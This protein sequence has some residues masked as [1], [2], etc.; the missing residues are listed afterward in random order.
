M[1]KLFIIILLIGCCGVGSGCQ[2]TLFR[3]KHEP[4]VKVK[5]DTPMGLLEHAGLLQKMGDYLPAVAKYRE[6]MVC[7]QDPLEIDLAKIG[8]AECLLKEKKYPAALVALE[9]LPLDIST[10]T[11]TKKLV[12]A[13]EI[14]LRQR[15]YAEAK[16][17][18]EIAM[19][20][21]DLETLLNRSK[22]EEMPGLENW[23][24]AAAANLGCAYLKNDEPEHA[25]V[26][27]QFAAHLYRAR[28]D[29]IQSQKSQRIH[30]DLAMVIQQYAPYKP[31]P[32]VKEIHA[33][34]M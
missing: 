34:R 1:K 32:V 12:L 27:Y 31:V 13:G 21:L 6:V 19:N 7:S 11:D 29:R 5:T 14:L 16:A 17:Y 23:I 18:L 20:S 8:A 26:M 4:P 33:G 10:E 24:P 15:R 2:T 22:S 30:D 3:K 25:L 28:G 9:P